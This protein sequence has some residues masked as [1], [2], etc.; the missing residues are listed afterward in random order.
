MNPA[1]LAALCT[2]LSGPRPRVVLRQIDRVAAATISPVV[3]KVSGLLCIK[4]IFNWGG[5]AA[6]GI[7]TGFTNLSNNNATA[8]VPGFRV[9]YKFLNGSEAR[10]IASAATASTEM[11]AI[12]YLVAGC[13]PAYIPQAGNIARSSTVSPELPSLTGVAGD[14]GRLWIAAGMS[15]GVVSLEKLPSDPQFKW[16]RTIQTLGS[17]L[18]Y[19]TDANSNM[20]IISGTGNAFTISSAVN[21]RLVLINV[22]GG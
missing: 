6:P 4:I 18:S 1:Q 7:P 11:T 8:T 13:N 14:T 10:A 21:S 19:A 20:R 3:P 15:V 5:T 2:I 12:S 9:V 22:R 17:N 16:D